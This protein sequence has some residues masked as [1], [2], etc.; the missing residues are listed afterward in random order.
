MNERL[1]NIQSEPR[2]DFPE[3]TPPPY[4]R[5]L[6]MLERIVGDSGASPGQNDI[7]PP[8]SDSGYLTRMLDNQKI[9]LTKKPESESGLNLSEE[10]QNL[11]GDADSANIERDHFLQVEE[12][13]ILL[14]I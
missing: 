6:E 7:S 4:E 13:K 11:F 5:A 9:E 14:I 8:A 10:M 1:S 12:T 3:L 2:E